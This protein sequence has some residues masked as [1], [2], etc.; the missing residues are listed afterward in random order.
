MKIYVTAF[1]LCLNL[2]F[3]ACDIC[4]SFMGIT[5]YDNQSQ[6]SL[7][8]RYRVFNGYRNYQQR[9][10]FI[11]PGAYRTMHDPSAGYGDSLVSIHNHS[12]KDYETFKVLELRGKCFVH[13]RWEINCIIP[14]QQIKLKYDGVKYTNTGMVDPSF[15]AGFHLVKRLNGYT[16]KQ[17]LIIGSG[18]KLPIGDYK[19]LSSDQQRYSLLTQNGTGSFDHFYYANYIVSK[20][21][22]GLSSNSLYKINGKNKFG[23]KFSNSYNQILSLFVKLAVKNVKIFPSV[24]GSYEFSRGLLIDDKIVPDTKMN[25]LLLGPAIDVNYKSFVFNASFQF[26]AYERVNSLSLSTAGRFVVGLTLN[27]GQGGSK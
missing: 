14:V 8:H 1:M 15:F 23:E 11:V 6:I 27:F 19:K 26:N 7:L 5:P 24:L 17:R 2:N 25:V 20:G 4:G 12:A 18:I 3:F 10:A 13:P 22:F 16:V 21:K 9:S